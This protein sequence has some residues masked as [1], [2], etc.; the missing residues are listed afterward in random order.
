LDLIGT[1]LTKDF[2]NANEN[3]RQLRAG[4]RRCWRLAHL[5]R[6]AALGHTH[7]WRLCLSDALLF[8]G[9]PPRLR[10]EQPTI[11]SECCLSVRIFQ[12]S[13]RSTADGRRAPRSE[14]RLRADGVKSREGNLP[15]S[16]KTSH[17]GKIVLTRREALMGLF[18]V[19]VVAGGR[20]GFAKA[21]QPSTPVNFAVPAHACDCHTHIF[22]PPDRFPF[23]AGR[24]YTPETAVPEEMAALH[25]ALHI[26]RVV[27]VTPSVYRTDNSATLFGMKARGASAR[28]IAVID[29]K[30]PESVLESM[31]R[32]G[33]RGV[34]LNLVVGGQS[35]S[36]AARRLLL[37]A[38]DRVKSRHWHVQIYTTPAVI[39][40]IKHAVRDSPVP[41]VFDHFGGALAALGLR[42]LGFA[43]L[44]D[45]VGSGKVYV[46]IS[47]AYRA[48][49][50][51]PDY[52]DVVPWHEP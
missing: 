21:S 39:S 20:A 34:R 33:I 36:V 17:V 3:C 10:E 38:A 50:R 15:K 51:A 12:Q 19:G 13:A 14:N 9:R 24:A 42:Q 16:E 25:R 41:V 6:G 5:L 22:G 28:G 52:P 35:S 31:D 26:E 30:T 45:L 18:A 1:S 8:I 27:I 48:S 37:R 7:F 44:L 43:D 2:V 40:G 29:E 4:R 32:A 11:H 47:G 23:W 49:K 46:K